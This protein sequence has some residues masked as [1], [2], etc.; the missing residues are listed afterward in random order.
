MTGSP[1][2]TPI[3]SLA[4]WTCRVL[5]GGG[6]WRH[7]VAVVALA[8]VAPAAHAADETVLQGPT[9]LVPLESVPAAIQTAPA[10][11]GSAAIEVNPLGAI[12]LDSVG[13]LGLDN[14]GFG[15]DLWQGTDRAIVENMLHQL[16]GD[17]RSPTLREL[18]RRML[19]TIATPPVVRNGAPPPRGS[20]LLAVRADRLAAMGEMDGLNE[21][22]A[23]VPSRQDDQTMA[24][25]RVDGLLVAQE[26]DEAC[27]QIRNGIAAFHAQPYWQKA[28]VFCNMIAGD[29]D[30]VMLGV[31]LLREVGA[32]DDP[33]FL[34][35]A[36]AA[37]SGRAEIPAGAS[38]TPL[39]LA[40]L[41]AAG[42]PVPPSAVAQAS[43]A[44]LVAIARS[45]TTDIVVRAQAAELACASGIVTGE[46]LA[47]I[48]NAFTFSPD[49]LANAISTFESGPGPM[50]RAMLYQAARAQNLPATRAEVLRVALRSDG[51]SEVY[52]AVVRAFLPLLME[53]PVNPELAWFA[54][55]AGRALYAAGRFEAASS[56]LALG[57]QEAILN[58][59]AA[60]A[61][62]VLWP[63]SRLAGDAALTTDGSLA[64]WSAMSG[65]TGDAAQA[66]RQSLL[67]AA[68]QALGE[69]DPLSWNTIAAAA[70]VPA[71]PLPAAALLYALQDASE[72]QRIGETVLLAIVVLGTSGPAD[73]HVMA[74][75]SAIAALNRVGLEQEARALAIEAAL[76]NGV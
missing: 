2:K 72:S 70:D 40:M 9:A 76:A 31:A 69:Q 75:S 24:R 35:L 26:N 7:C 51:A 15:Q 16:P 23:V 68:F 41:G 44:L 73:S 11:P 28:M 56:W 57:R 36:S 30:K 42:E 58:P 39:H 46:S 3:R 29:T 33:V 50:A 8:V 5:R 12:S 48:Y 19:L 54:G 38:L 71:R 63:Y 10:V 1:A 52:Q 53:I 22:L 21:L 61:V 65:T 60:T 62:A 25:A 43:P 20:R 17:V 34:T 13:V 49:Q 66:R 18:A 64:A 14:G 45:S 74:L 6:A 55:T 67:R 4:V 37:L 32:A 27:R 47:Q 59:R